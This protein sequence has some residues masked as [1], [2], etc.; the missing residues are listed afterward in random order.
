MEEVESAVYEEVNKL[1]TQPVADWEL[2]KV[3]LRYRHDHAAQMSS[4]LSRAVSLAYYA[5]A[6]NDPEV[7]NT[8]EVRLD[9]VTRDDLVRVAK[10]YL[11]PTNR[12]VITT[13][14]K[15]KSA[16]GSTGEN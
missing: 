7:I 13:I 4:T 15:P 16:A 10:T 9:T 1:Q 3:R 8:E 14:P 11:I 5:V 12:S 2:E 6:W